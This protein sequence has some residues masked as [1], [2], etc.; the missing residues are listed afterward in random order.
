MITLTQEQWLAEATKRYGSLGR[1]FRFRCPACGH[2]QSGDDFLALGMTPELVTKRL[3]FSCI[4]RWM[5]ECREAFAKGPGP[6][7]YA[8]GGLIR[9]GP[10]LVSLDGKV[11]HVFDFAD[12]PLVETRTPAAMG[13]Q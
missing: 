11:L 5:P 12:E 7:N 9:I 10:V 8:G 4:G 13:V 6:C 3:G 2:V 1:D